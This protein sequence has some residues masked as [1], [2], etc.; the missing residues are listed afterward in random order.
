MQAPS[1]ILLLLALLYAA[2]ALAQ[3][4]SFD[5]NNATTASEIA[6]CGNP[7]L[8]QLDR[9]V[10]LA[11]AEASRS[12]GRA[13]A[14]AVARRGLA[15]RNACESDVDC[16]TAAQ[17]ASLRDFQ[18]LGATI[19]LPDWSENAASQTSSGA[20]T[21]AG[22][23]TEVGQC[24]TTEITGITSRFQPDINADPNDGSAVSFQNGGYQVSYEK[25][26]AIIRS[27]VGDPVK[28]CL[29]SIPEDCPPGDDRGRFYTTTNLRTGEAWSLPD[30]QH[31]CGGA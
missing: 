4:P 24:T 18:S 16:I 6:I 15:A 5:C 27:R 21:G 9:L 26:Q 30:S 11:F 22:L 8:S 10:A 13:S 17:F 3:S 29:V 12:A 7:E 14:R 23:P 20:A 1:P 28:M 25:E 19:A 2:P 31:M